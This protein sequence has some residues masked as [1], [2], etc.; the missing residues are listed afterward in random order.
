MSEEKEVSYIIFHIGS[1]PVPIVKK[2]VIGQFF[3]SHSI[4]ITILDQ[5]KGVLSIYDVPV[6]G[7]GHHGGQKT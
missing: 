3:L 5:T 2:G 7:R 6:G 4:R 1:S